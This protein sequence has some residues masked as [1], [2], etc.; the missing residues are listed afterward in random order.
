MQK[1]YSG[2]LCLLLFFLTGLSDS[3]AQWCHRIGAEHLAPGV[4][5]GLTQTDGSHWVAGMYRG[6]L[7]VGGRATPVQFTSPTTGDVNQYR[8]SGFLAKYTPAGELA[9]AR[10]IRS[11]FNRLNLQQITQG[12]NGAVFLTGGFNGPLVF[13]PGQPNQ[14]VLQGSGNFE[15]IFIARIEANGDVAWVKA[16]PATDNFFS[17]IP[18]FHWH[19]QKLYL[20]V[21]LSI[22]DIDFDP[23]PT[24]NRLFAPFI[25]VGHQN[26]AMAVYNENGLLEYAGHF[27]R[28]NEL[29]ISN[30]AS[31][32]T[33]LVISLNFIDSATLILGSSTS[34]T[35][36]RA[37][38]IGGAA[39]ILSNPTTAKT[40]YQPENIDSIANQGYYILSAARIGQS[41]H[42]IVGV[43]G[44]GGID[45][46]P[47]TPIDTALNN[48]VQG[49][50]QFEVMLSPEGSYEGSREIAAFTGGS[51]VSRFPYGNADSLVVI[52]GVP[53]FVVNGTNYE[54]PNPLHQLNAVLKRDGNQFTVRKTFRGQHNAI[55]LLGRNGG[56]DY[57][58]LRWQD[59]LLIDNQPFQQGSWHFIEVCQITDG[60]LS[61]SAPET[62]RQDLSL[63]LYPNPASDL[64]YIRYEKGADATLRLYDLAG[65]QV[66]TTRLKAGE[67]NTIDISQLSAGLYAW[68]CTNG[69]AFGSGKVIVQ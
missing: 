15:T 41:I 52:F 2:S 38:G 3:Q 20:G 53:G 60:G 6:S 55:P 68:K 54:S 62:E 5:L 30:A 50:R 34:S 19:E 10:E 35:G 27:A 22:G 14:I 7:E 56:Y 67:T 16:L 43:G 28:G 26:Y 59:S 12:P 4:N 18:L 29:G 48:Y 1:L 64:L 49:Y 25:T 13:N 65:R 51:A 44:N 47:G 32:D 40:I 57:L 24:T 17:I 61:L 46:D 66:L 11:T 21:R 23:E 37:N 36:L 31:S 33:D 69:E 42:Q 8:Y 58:Q 45:L 63:Q 39:V 9:W